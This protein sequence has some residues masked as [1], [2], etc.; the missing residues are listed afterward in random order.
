LEADHGS[1]FWAL[2]N[3]VGLDGDLSSADESFPSGEVVISIHISG[4]I[5]VAEG[6]VG[7]ECCGR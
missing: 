7:A 5:I 4:L 2:A 6:A 3:E 1:H